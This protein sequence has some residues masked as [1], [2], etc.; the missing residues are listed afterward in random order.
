LYGNQYEL[1][2]FMNDLKRAIVEEDI[3]TNVNSFRQNLQLT[4]V[5]RLIE[6][7]AGSSSSRFKPMAKSMALQNLNALHKDLKS[8]KGN[9]SSIA[10]K[11]HLKLLIKNALKKVN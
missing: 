5:K 10:H 7:V 8:P 4:Y 3:K 11:N 9:L 6:M 2:E 1:A